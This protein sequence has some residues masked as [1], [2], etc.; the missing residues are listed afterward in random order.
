[1]IRNRWFHAQRG[2]VMIRRCLERSLLL[3]VLAGVCAFGQ[4]RGLGFIIFGDWGRS[5]RSHQ[6]DVAN[7]MGLAANAGG[8]DF[9]ISTGDNFQVKGVRSTGDPLWKTNFETIYTR[10]SLL[11]P[12]YPVLGNH[13]YLGSPRAEIDYSKMSRRWHMPARYWALHKKLRDSTAIDFF[14]L[15]TSPF[16]KQYRRDKRYGDLT[17]QDT[18][19]QLIWLDS[20]LAASTAQWKFVVGHHP[21][22]SGGMHDPDLE[23]MAPRFADMFSRHGVD[24]YFA[25]HDHDFEHIRQNGSSVNYF[26]V[27][28]GSQVRPVFSTSGTLF[29]KSVPGFTEVFVTRDTMTVKAIDYQGNMFYTTEIVKPVN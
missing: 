23:D 20:V 10:K 4:P 6:R 2:R 27:G 14:F 8:I 12:W 16:Q 25:G 15:D 21:V 18:L 3:C 1:M 7:E 19:R 11:K 9:I 13:D 26:V 24:A 28:T 29:A 5:G 17:K 22:Y